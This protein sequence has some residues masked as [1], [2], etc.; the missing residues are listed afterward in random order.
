MTIDFIPLHI[1]STIYWWI[2][3]IF[4]AFTM[5]QLPKMEEGN[6]TSGS[7]IAWTF[8]AIFTVIYIGFRPISSVFVDMTAYA[9]AFDLVQKGADYAMS[10]D[11]GFNTFLTLSANLVSKPVFFF[12]CSLLYVIP[13]YIACRR[14]SNSHWPLLFVAFLGS[15]SFWAYGVN[16]IRHGIATS[17]LIFAFSIASR[18]PSLVVSGLAISFH[19]SVM[20][21]AIGYYLAST[22]INI[23]WFFRFWMLAIPLSLILGGFWESLIA[24]IGLGG[25]DDRLTAY[26]SASTLGSSFGKFR[27]DF[28]LY[29]GCGVAAGYFYT[30]VSKF[31]DLFYK[32]ILGA[33]LFSNAIW[34]LIIRANFSNRFAYLSWFIMAFVIFYPLAK[35]NIFQTNSATTGLLLILYCLF[36]FGMHVL[37][38]Q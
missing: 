36:S 22:R 33:Y 1:Y 5:T 2:I 15:F 7:Y 19:K 32:K 13:V 30:Y 18:W 26:L 6:R 23:S 3:L 28:L 29:S 8:L 11:T 12:L 9:G 38:S 16:G 10:T 37:I 14:W 24:G 35:A 25:E 20:L 17:L 4:A 34:I 27:W 31:D 21:P